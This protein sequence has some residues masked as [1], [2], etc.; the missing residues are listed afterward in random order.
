MNRALKQDGTRH[1]CSNNSRRKARGPLLRRILVFFRSAGISVVRSIG[2]HQLAQWRSP[3]ITASRSANKGKRKE[4]SG[5]RQRS[6][7]DSSTEQATST[8]IKQNERIGAVGANSIS[9]SPSHGIAFG[10][11]ILVD[12]LLRGVDSSCASDLDPFA[13]ARKIQSQVAAFHKRSKWT[14]RKHHPD[15][16]AACACILARTPGCGVL[17]VLTASFARHVISV[18]CSQADDFLLQIIQELSSSAHKHGTGATPQR[19]ESLEHSEQHMHT[20]QRAT[21]EPNAVAGCQ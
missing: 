18:S 10:V 20:T 7:R 4:S 2:L 16:R 5:W 9:R 8:R 11:A 21:I 14:R 19:S 15:L 17:A 13:L 12:E 6:S 3:S 1:R